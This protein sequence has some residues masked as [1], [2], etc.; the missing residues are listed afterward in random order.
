MQIVQLTDD[1]FDE[2]FELCQSMVAE[3]E[4]KDA[5]PDKEII[6]DMY[7]DSNGV[8]FL[9]EKDG[10]FIGFIAGVVQRYFFSKR[11]RACDMGFYVLPEHRGSRAAI[12]LIKT[13]EYWAQEMGVE[14][15]AIGQTTA[16]DIEKTLRFYAHLGYKVVGFNTV[17]HLKQGG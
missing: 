16:V 1:R 13:F 3:A 7:S 4:F 10:K 6:W 14:E 12:R 9:A 11:Q 17:K 8:V 15:I 2:F 5:E